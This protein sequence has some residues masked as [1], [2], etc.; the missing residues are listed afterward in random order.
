MAEI[1]G[2]TR[3]NFGSRTAWV[4]RVRHGT[5]IT[6]RLVWL[7]GDGGKLLFSALREDGVTWTPAIELS[8]LYSPRGSLADAR[9]AVAAWAARQEE[10]ARGY[11]G[12]RRRWR[13]S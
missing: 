5:E 4:W 11:R 1:T 3:L 13:A 2:P 7:P 10:R 6:H 8:G 9:S 12:A